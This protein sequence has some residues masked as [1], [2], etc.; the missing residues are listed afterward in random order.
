MVAVALAAGLVVACGS[1]SGGG[2][3]G[4]NQPVML[5]VENNNWQDARIYVAGLG[6]PIR[7]GSVTSLGSRRF[8]IPSSYIRSQGLRLMVRLLASSETTATQTFSVLPGDR[9]ELTVE[10]Q[11]T[12]TNYAVFAPAY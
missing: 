6:A 11:L 8:R 3:S 10:N 7:L 1:R 9:V 12:L 5:E 4:M 2:A